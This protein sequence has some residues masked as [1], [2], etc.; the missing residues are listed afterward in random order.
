MKSHIARPDNFEPIHRETVAEYLARGGTITRGMSA[1]G[2]TYETHELIDRLL[3]ASH[4]DAVTQRVSAF[5]VDSDIRF[6]ID[7][8]DDDCILDKE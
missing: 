7:S 5:N 8:H 6:A 4:D 3:G 2:V 1:S